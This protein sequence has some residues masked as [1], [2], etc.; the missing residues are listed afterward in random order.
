MEPGLLRIVIIDD[1]RWVVRAVRRVRGERAPLFPS[2]RFFNGAVSRY[3]ND[4][5]ANWPSLSE[6]ELTSIFQR[7]EP[8]V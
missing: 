1:Q 3:A 7:A 8:L 2:L 4:Y 5:P 6:S